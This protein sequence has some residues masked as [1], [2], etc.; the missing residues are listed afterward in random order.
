MVLE[1]RMCGDQIRHSLACDGCGDR[2][3]AAAAVEGDAVDLWLAAFGRG[4]RLALGGGI[5]FRHLCP[6]CS[7]SGGPPRGAPG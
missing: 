6:S 1:Q 3:E 4:W 2:Y 5:E 7:P